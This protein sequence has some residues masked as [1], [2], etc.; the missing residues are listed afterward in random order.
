VTLLSGGDA[1]ADADT[2]TP[3]PSEAVAGPR[4]LA[5]LV[6]GLA[7]VVVVGIDLLTKQL[8]LT[9]LSDGSVVRV[10]GG[11]VYFDLTRNSGAA[12]SIGANITVLFPI[13]TVVVLSG[14]VWLARRL[15]SVPWALSMGLIV[16]GAL[17]NLIDRLFRAPAPLHGHVVDF[18]SLFAPAG[19]RFA[20]F[21]AA[22]SA[23]SCGVVLAIL[24]EF[25]G[26]RRD[27]TRVSGKDGDNAGAKGP[28]G[29]V[30]DFQREDA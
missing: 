7:A 16:G 10:L 12:F 15:R 6:L 2:P 21:N 22:D 26:R 1:V 27:G 14:V 9:N 20:I 23:L 5:L 24:L 11:A 13:I 28:T 3:A 30:R 17:G 4:G 25:T 8:A 18:I 19:E 29:G